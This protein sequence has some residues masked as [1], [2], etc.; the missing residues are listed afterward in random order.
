MAEA[1][2]WGIILAATLAGCAPASARHPSAPDVHETADAAVARA[3]HCASDLDLLA[4]SSPDLT[5]TALQA[6]TT[7]IRIA[8]QA[9][10]DRGALEH[11][12]RTEVA[13]RLQAVLDSRYAVDRLD[14]HAGPWGSPHDPEALVEHVRSVSVGLCRT[15]DAAQALTSGSAPIA[16]AAMS[17]LLTVEGARD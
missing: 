14:A 10:A 8:A 7:A 5:W 11:R 4:A 1:R 3:I 2:S 17:R 12:G 6:E 16:P 15:R 9:A 13:R